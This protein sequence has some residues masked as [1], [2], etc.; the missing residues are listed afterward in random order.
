MDPIFRI[1]GYIDLI[2]RIGSNIDLKF[3][4]KMESS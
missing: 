3:R 1:G 4:M 2:F